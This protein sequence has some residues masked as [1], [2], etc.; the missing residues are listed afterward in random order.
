VT[1]LGARCVRDRCPRRLAVAALLAGA[2]LVAGPAAAENST[3]LYTGVGIIGLTVTNLGYVGNGFSSPNQPSCEYPLNSNVEH[4][5]LGGLWVGA[6]TA[7]GTIRV[8]TGAQ[9]SATLEDGE[10]DREFKEYFNLADPADPRNK[11]YVWSNSQ[12]SD[13]F[14]PRA[15]ATQHIEVYMTDYLDPPPVGYLPLGLEVTLRGLA[16]APPYAD[17][18]V[19]LDYAISNV[20]G[21]EMRDVYVGFWNDC[22]VGNTEHTVPSQYDPNAPVGWNFYDDK[23]GAWGADGWV[24]P[25][26]SV[27][28]DPGIWMMHEHDADTDEGLAPSWVGVRLLGT[29]PSVQPPL[30]QPPVS[31][32]AWMFRH[33]PA[34]DDTYL[35]DNGFQ[36]PGKY[37]I[38]SNGA[39]TVGETQETDYTTASD[40]VG[41]LSTGPWPTLAPDDTVHVTFAVVCGGDSLALLANSRVAQLAYDQGFDL[42]GGPP[43]PLLDV[44]YEW[45]TVKLRW[46]PGDS[47]GPDGGE[48]PPQDP[49][50]SPE[51][52]ISEITDKLDFQGYRIYRYQGLNI[53][54]DPYELATVVAEFD[55]IDGFGFDTG[56]PPLNADGQ[57]EFVDAGLLDGFPYWYSVISFSAPDVEEGL[58]E[59]QS[60]F[61]E[62]SLLVYPGPAARASSGEGKVG[63]APNPYRAGSAF[64]NP[65]GEVELGRRIWFMNLPPRCT[66]KIFTLAGDLVRTLDHADPVEGKHAWDVLSE[67]G[68]AI[69]TGLYVWVV[70]NLDS[71]E[72]QRG[73]LVIIK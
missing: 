42:P 49:R 2:S 55:K 38:M 16:W 21:V 7:D 27:A 39:F 22:S 52:H 10:S 69:A 47:L 64:D 54:R 62:N 12:N 8:T 36:Q 57:R 3:N 48:L 44:A 28:A 13:D 23:N 15:L 35:D 1:S 6:V 67:Y 33:V 66:I 18:F 5:F 50:R 20:S 19:I 24:D 63:V 59:F 31:Y 29:R 58:P 51:Q 73:K 46:A 14:D 71:G 26:Y 30:E 25:A 65:G 9:D 17:D 37:Q 70:E 34:E 68:R 40:W 60:G 43:S 72:I 53:D 11:A 56:L 4:M 45:D 61:N 41:L 32:N